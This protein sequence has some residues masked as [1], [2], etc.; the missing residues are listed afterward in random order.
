VKKIVLSI[1]ALVATTSLFASDVT[2]ECQKA[3]AEEISSASIET[4]SLMTVLSCKPYVASE[5]PEVQ[6]VAV[7]EETDE[8]V[9]EAHAPQ[10]ALVEEPAVSLL[11]MDDAPIEI[12]VTEATVKSG[13]KYYL[14]K[15]KKCHGNGTVGAS[16][17]SQDEWAELFNGF[18]NGQAEIIEQHK[19]TKVEKFFDS[20]KFKDK[21]GIPLRDFL[22]NYG[23]DSGNVPSCG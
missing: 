7:V 23:N 16:M 4:N 15:C 12:T 13:Q 3:T 9:E 20:D 5:E 17:H 11:P 2:L 10:V 6:E 8:V 21:Y 1:S 18:E 14:K 22:Y 19:G